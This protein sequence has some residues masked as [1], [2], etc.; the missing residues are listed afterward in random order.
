[1]YCLECLRKLRI[2][3]GA[4]TFPGNSN[5]STKVSINQAQAIP[6]FQSRNQ[7]LNHAT[8]QGDRTAHSEEPTLQGVTWPAAFRGCQWISALPQIYP[9]HTGLGPVQDLSHSCD[10]QK[11][12]SDG[13]RAPSLGTVCMRGKSSTFRGL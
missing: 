3:P 4:K 9:S 12:C 7:P 6:W 11:L 1:M 13:G 2:I 10:S 5:F 8:E